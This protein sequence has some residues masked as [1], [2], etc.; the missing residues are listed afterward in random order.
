VD[1]DTGELVKNLRAERHNAFTKKLAEKTVQHFACVEG[2]VRI[3]LGIASLGGS[4]TQALASKI[5][6]LAH[7]LTRRKL[8]A[9]PQDFPFPKPA[10][11]LPVAPKPERWQNAVLY[12]PSCLTR[13][14]GKLDGEQVRIGLADAVIAVFRACGY[15][16]YIPNDVHHYCCGQPYLSKGFFDA[17]AQ[18][19]RRMTDFLWDTTRGGEVPVV[20]DTSSCSYTLIRSY[21]KLLSGNALKR[22]Q[23]LRLYDFPSFFVQEVLPKR[24]D[25]PKLDRRIVLHPVCALTKLG[26]VDDFCKLAE[27]FATHV[28]LPLN[29]GCCGFAGDRGYLVP[30]LTR[31]ATKAEA[32]EVWLAETVQGTKFDGYYSTNRACEIGLSAATGRTYESIVYLCYEALC[33]N[34]A[35]SQAQ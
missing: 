14:I 17:A 12:L 11:P 7:K 34:E 23:A 3:G 18:A 35:R 30:E 29:S 24:T 15:T 1:I 10:P 26:N 27:T 13:A 19:A 4:T 5:T 21:S 16:P 8:P 32:Q 2:I 28:T 20:C 22:W 31:S 9:I 33:K 6:S 25:W